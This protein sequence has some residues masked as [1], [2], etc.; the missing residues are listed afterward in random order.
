[1]STETSIEDDVRAALGRDQRIKHPDLIAVSVDGI[2]TVVLRGAVESPVQRHAAVEDARHTDRVFNV[3]DE[4]K[5]HP[6]VAHRGTDDRIRAEALR[7]LTSDPTFRNDDIDV[8]VSDGRITLTG[9]VR[10]DS[11]IASAA[12]AVE[13]VEGVAGVISELRTR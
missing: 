2:G 7:R 11:S 5:V 4:L 6:P 13:G 12:E 8:E 3:I 10:D 9:R 1:M